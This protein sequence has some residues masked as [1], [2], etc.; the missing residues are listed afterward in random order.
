MISPETIARI[1]A[2]MAEASVFED[3][4]EESFILGGGPGGQ[5][6]NKT[7]SVVRLA[8]A[9]SGLQ[10][11]CGETRSRET[12]RW[13]ARRMLA[14]AILAREKVSVECMPA[15][16]DSVTVVFR[17]EQF[18]DEVRERVFAEIEEELHPDHMSYTRGIAFLVAVGEG[19]R[20]TVGTCLHV[21]TAL[22][23]AGVNLQMINQG[24]SELSIMFGIR[25][26]DLKPAVQ[27][28]YREFF[29]A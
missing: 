20:T 15:G 3:D 17:D 12:N 8:H 4:L 6:T 11:R 27:A 1:E 16:V 14:E 19:M 23:R 9:P 21:V 7:S 13:L 28:L 5:K 18:P 2:M 22:S 29:G 26:V 10:V 24:S 25:E